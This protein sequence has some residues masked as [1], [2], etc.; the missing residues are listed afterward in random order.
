[1]REQIALAEMWPRHQWRVS[2]LT[3]STVLAAKAEWEWSTLYRLF[4]LEGILP[5]ILP[6]LF[7]ILQDLFLKVTVLPILVIWPIETMVS[8]IS[9]AWRVSCKMTG[10]VL[11]LLGTSIRRSPVP[12]A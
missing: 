8:T 9:G 7:L 3:F 12:I 1:M 10:V 11:S 5:I 2:M 4:E 6:D